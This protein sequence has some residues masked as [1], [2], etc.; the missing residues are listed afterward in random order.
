MSKFKVTEVSKALAGIVRNFIARCLSSLQ[1]AALLVLSI[2]LTA[3]ATAP[4]SVGR[5]STYHSF[6]FNTRKD[7]PNVELLDYRYGNSTGPVVRNHDG[8]GNSRQ[9]GGI[10]G[11]ITRGDDL[12]VK[13]RMKDSGKVFEDTVDLKSRLPRDIKN[14]SIYFIVDKSQLHVYLISLFPVRDYLTRDEEIEDL[15]AKQHS[16]HARL[17]WYA[18]NNVIQIYPTRLVIYPYQSKK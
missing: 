10:L 13:W 14:H 17:M 11:D 15:I 2:A 1:L 3:C 6:D 8:E 5:E 12:Y 9:Y 16:V 4:A 7:S 18:R